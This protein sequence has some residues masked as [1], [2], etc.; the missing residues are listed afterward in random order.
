MAMNYND[1]VVSR[2][3]PVDDGA[4]Q[5]SLRDVLNAL[6]PNARASKVALFKEHFAEIDAAVSRNVS[7]ADIL[8]A[9]AKRGLKLSANTFNKM[10]DAERERRQQSQKNGEQSDEAS[11]NAT[12]KDSQ[13]VRND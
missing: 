6:N 12:G 8:A 2:E 9:L 7:K 11:T 1:H 13:E 5:L 4:D 3:A 10:L